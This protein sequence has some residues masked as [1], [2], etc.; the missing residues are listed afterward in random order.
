MKTT[1]T[2]SLL[3]LLLSL[4]GCSTSTRIQSVQPA[5][6]Q[7]A[8]ALQQIAVLEFDEKNLRDRGINMGSKIEARLASHQIHGEN[9]FTVVSRADINSVLNEQKLQSSGLVNEQQAASLG[10]LAGVQA[11][12]T[13]TLSSSSIEDARINESR[14]KCEK[15]ECREYEVSCTIR[16][17]QLGAQIRMIDVEQASLITAQSYNETTSWKHCSDDKNILPSRAQALEHVSSMVAQSFVSQITPQLKTFKV[18]LYDKPDIKLPA[19]Q[20]LQFKSALQFIKAQRM[21]RAEQLLEQLLDYSQQ[22]SFSIAYNLGVV[23]EASGN[24]QQA[25]HLY[26]LADSISLA[27][28]K[29]INQALVRIDSTLKQNQNLNQRK[30]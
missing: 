6:I 27:P 16:T 5:Q 24:Y 9:Y 25:Q 22:Q 21:D 1:A 4:G 2:L 7:Q 3:A 28:E 11:L 18:K 14:K 15:K 30:Q 13:G 10:K 20:Q 26:Q 8:A 12:I 19:H 29:N 17:A 23:K